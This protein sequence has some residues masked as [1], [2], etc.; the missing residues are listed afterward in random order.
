MIWKNLCSHPHILP[1]LGVDIESF[2]GEMC[3]VSE[4]MSNGTIIEFLKREPHHAVEKYVSHA[5]DNDSFMLT[6]TLVLVTSDCRGHSIPT[7]ARDVPWRFE[8]GEQ[9][10]PTFPR[11]LAIVIVQANI[12]VGSDRKAKIADF[13]F[14]NFVDM[15]VTYATVRMG[16]P[17]WMAPELLDTSQKFQRT[18]KS[19]IFA[20][21]CIAFEVALQ[22]SFADARERLTLY[23]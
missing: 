10:P 1:F 3:M 8:R 4:W 22:L 13:G 18:T 5:Q 16:T 6:Q 21:A 2:P 12:L 20:F 14:A 11:T 19:D 9:L 23:N 15:S 17:K 7:L